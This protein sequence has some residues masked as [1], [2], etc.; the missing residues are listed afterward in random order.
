MSP[1]PPAIV[2]A[3]VQR[4]ALSAP[5]G[6]LAARVPLAEDVTFEADSGGHTDNRP[7]T[8]LLPTLIALRDEPLDQALHAVSGWHTVYVAGDRYRVWLRNPTR[9]VRRGDHLRT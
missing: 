9:V 8:A 1:A 7:L 4:G 6:E 2:A 5:E 3:L